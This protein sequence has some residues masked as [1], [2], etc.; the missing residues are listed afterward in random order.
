M[1]SAVLA[2]E[3]GERRREWHLRWLQSHFWFF[4]MCRNIRHSCSQVVHAPDHDNVLVQLIMELHGTLT[5][6]RNQECNTKSNLQYADMF[7]IGA[8]IH[9]IY[10]L[11]ARL[12]TTYFSNYLSSSHAVLWVECALVLYIPSEWLVN[13][14]QI[15][16]SHTPWIR[17][18]TSGR[19]A[20]IQ[21]SWIIFLRT[22]TDPQNLW[23][24]SPMK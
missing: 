20:R 5:Q 11:T 4:F 14:L 8:T 10:A 19:S 1:T 15:A 9:K 17:T 13:F 21:Y 23:K 16:I 24:F 22:G 7:D 12:T 6:D 18:S 2:R 3:E